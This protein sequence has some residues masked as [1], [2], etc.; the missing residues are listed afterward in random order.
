M[1]RLILVL[2]LLLAALSA[3]SAEGWPAEG[4]IT[5]SVWLSRGNTFVKDMGGQVPEKAAE[6]GS[7]YAPRVF[8]TNSTGEKQT[9]SMSW[10]VDGT[11][12]LTF[13][14]LIAQPGE[15]VSATMAD[16]SA[17]LYRA[18]GEHSLA[19]KVN[20]R[21]VFTWSWTALCDEPRPQPTARPQKL[22][23]VY[24]E[25][26]PENLST[27]GLNWRYKAKP[28]SAAKTLKTVTAAQVTEALKTGGTYALNYKLNTRMIEATRTFR[29]DIVMVSPDGFEFTVSGSMTIRSGTGSISYDF[30]GDGFFKAYKAA[31]GKILQGKYQLKLYLND[32]LANISTV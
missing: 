14:D 9:I 3:V 24:Q 30:L 19:V 21:D 29:A 26:K 4:D 32:M 16:V 12:T 11:D 1:K 23:F 20:G 10:V 31:R 8:I 5:A 6:K 22:N 13:A 7:Y 2:A 17:A 15:T 18:K 25:M 27:S 28:G